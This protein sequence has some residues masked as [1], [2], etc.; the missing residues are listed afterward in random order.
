MIEWILSSEAIGALCAIHAIA[1]RRRESTGTLAWA[2][3]VFVPFLGPP[4]YL[5]LGTDRIGRRRRRRVMEIRELHRKHVEKAR[6]CAKERRLAVADTLPLAIS[7]QGF[8]AVAFGNTTE[9]L[10]DGSEVFRR[11]IE[12]VRTATQSVDIL[13]YIVDDDEETDRLKQALL[14][15]L[16]RGVSVRII[17][18]GIGALGSGRFLEDLEAE[19]AKCLEFIPLNPLRLRFRMSLRNH[20]KLIVV[21]GKTGFIGSMNLSGRH[22][23]DPPKS[24]DI[25]VRVTGDVVADMRH[26]FEEDWRFGEEENRRLFFGGANDWPTF[27]TADD[28]PKDGC[29]VEGDCVQLVA[30]GPDDP[31][32]GVMRM[33]VTAIHRAEISVDLATPYFVPSQ[34]LLGAIQSAAA[35]GV[36]VRLLVSEKTDSMVVDIAMTLWLGLVIER[37]VEV[38]ATKKGFIHEKFAVIDGRVAFMGSSNLD[39]RSAFLN[40][41]ADLVAYAGSLPTRL[42]EHFA[43]RWKD[44]PRYTIP[45]WLLPR[46]A[47]A[48][49]DESAVWI[50]TGDETPRWM[51]PFK[52]FLYRL[53]WLTSPLL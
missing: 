2:A 27:V 6:E 11:I 44:A 42:T 18:D 38:R 21:D 48:S 43:T 52:R 28:D 46:A 17:Y 33:L 26:V 49:V 29:A 19:G 41:E 53:V 12:D 37:D 1:T 31:A 50:K 40:F 24:Q 4:L 34:A 15:A 3:W 25:V 23:G 30:S 35:R 45:I 39:Q 32:V 9:L 22:V 16:R 10:T 51:W 13:S 36:Q 20:R 47:R 8:F 14:D 7:D 5:L